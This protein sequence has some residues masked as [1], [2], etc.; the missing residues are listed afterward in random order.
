MPSRRRKPPPILVLPEALVTPGL[1]EK[2]CSVCVQ[3][4]VKRMSHIGNNPEPRLA[5]YASVENKTIESL[6]CQEHKNYK[7]PRSQLYQLPMAPKHPF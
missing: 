7:T 6:Y 2:S 3:E 5:V 4:H 1:L